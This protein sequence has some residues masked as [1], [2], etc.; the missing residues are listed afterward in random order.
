MA[1]SGA[2]VALGAGLTPFMSRPSKG[3]LTGYTFV[4]NEKSHELT[5]LAPETF[6]VV[7]KIPT[8]RRPRGMVFNAEHSLLYVACGDEDV[9]DVVDVADQRVVDGIPTGPSPEVLTISP[10]EK[11]MFIANEEDSSMWIISIEDRVLQHEVPSGAE[12]E[13]VMVTPDG[14]TVYLTSEV[15]DMIHKVDV[16]QGII[17]QNVIVG[18]RPRRIRITP[19]GKE[20][21]VSCELS[22]EIYII[23]VESYQVTDVINFLPPGFRQVD[24]TP[25]GLELNAAGTRVYATL[26]RANHL[27][28]VDVQSREI[29]DYILVGSRAW[30]I[31]ITV[32]EKTVLVANGLSDDISVIDE[33]TR[34]VRKSVRVGRVPYIPLIDDRV[35]WAPVGN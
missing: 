25:V 4:S 34:R 35:G 3:L 22:G 24:V 11:L 30:G 10:D 18:T 5:V 16:E 17:T 29:T 27:A 15:A 32:D 2:A 19:D 26:G 6:E 23:D 8:S 14:K 31:T 9:I 21:W 7:N 13:G 1:S 20:M 28:Y 33:E 12:P